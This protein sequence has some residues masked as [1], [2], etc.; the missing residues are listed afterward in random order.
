MATLQTRLIQIQGLVD[1]MLSMAR[2]VCASH[3]GP[4]TAVQ[5][6]ALQVLVL[7]ERNLS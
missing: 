3:S 1:N 5:R 6:V 4:P 2:V 7:T